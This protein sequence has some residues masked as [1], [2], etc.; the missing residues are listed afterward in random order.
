MHMLYHNHA[1]AIV[2]I[3]DLVDACTTKD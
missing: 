3:T 2:R 1:F